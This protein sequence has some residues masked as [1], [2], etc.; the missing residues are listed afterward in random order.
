MIHCKCVKCGE[1]EVFEDHKSAWLVGWD[2]VGQKSYCGECSV[3]P[4]PKDEIDATL[5]T[6]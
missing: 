4:S 6:N 2:F 1:Q 3:M 5:Q